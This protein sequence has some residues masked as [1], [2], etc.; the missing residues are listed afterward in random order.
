MNN[1]QQ[2]KQQI[3]KLFDQASAV[4]NLHR[5]SQTQKS[6]DEA[7]QHL[8]E[9]KLFVV[10]CGE[11]KQGKSSL[12][13]AFLNEKDLFPVDTDI[14][15][16]L[17]STITYGKEEKIS[18]ILGEQGNETV[19]QIS[20]NE[21]PDYVTEQRNIRNAKKA[22]MLVIESPNPQLKEGLVLVDTPGVG[23]LNTEHTAITYA[24]IPNADAILFVTDILKP[25]TTE[26]LQFLKERIFPHCQNIIFVVTKID[27]VNN[28]QEIVENNLEKLTKVLDCSREQISIIP[29]SSRAKLDY[30]KFKEKEDLELSN[31]S[32][33][34]NKIWQFISEQ[35]G[36]GLLL[37]A[38]NEL[39][40]S[41]NEMKAPIEVAVEAHQN[42][43]KEELDE[44]E[45]QMKDT[46]EQ[47]QDL[48][49]SKAEWRNILTDSL[50]DIKQ[51]L[52]V[53]FQQN[54][55]QIRSQ[56][57][58]YLDDPRLMKNP[59]QIASLV[60]TDIDVLMSAL[61]KDLN[62][63]AA[64]LY[65]QIE[66]LSG[67]KLRNFE[68]ELFDQQKAH[69]SQETVEVQQSSLLDKSMSA[70]RGALFNSTAGSIIGGILG[71]VV[72][73]IAGLFVGGV[74]AFPGAVAGAQIGAG[75]GTIGGAATGVKDGISQ[76]QEKDQNRL[77][78]EVSRIITPFI[79]DSQRICHQTLNKAVKGL[80]RSMRD[81]FTN[82]IKRQK[83]GWERTLRS[84]QVS[85]KLS[86][87]KAIQQAKELQIPL[88]QLKQL[89]TT[90]EQL[91]Q[92]IVE[93]PI[94]IPSIQAPSQ[95]KVKTPE[96]PSKEPAKVSTSANYDSGDWADE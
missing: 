34:E 69:L 87:S 53:K 12:I 1:Y 27:A 57:T 2:R 19:K 42:R 61:S 4:A 79:E 81:E 67:L 92:A 62:Q 7:K 25:L 28:F 35:R 73:G 75:L 16:N 52:L 18:I 89:Q 86:Q 26:E 91:T 74:G 38:L 39:E 33:L 77:K 17:V 21:I 6:L 50:E 96:K 24:F 56:T 9:G 90:I 71:G 93:Q 43:T 68:V 14:T 55:S 60:E 8:K 32:E 13:N 36:Q 95:P 31:F 11:F 54:F 84:L 20:R 51:E 15:T 82:Q 59:K 3:L 44:L 23:S 49:D 5:Y 85:R 30:L 83:E 70:T 76:V 66:T 63:Q 47:L 46:Q 58:K 45:Q 72:G 94:S 64:D 37:R 29:I 78:R 88:Q 80:E 40:Q 22:K 41:V 10:V 65:G 48:L